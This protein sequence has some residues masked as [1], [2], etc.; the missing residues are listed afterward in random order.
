MLSKSFRTTDAFIKNKNDD[1]NESNFVMN[2]A[3]KSY[4]NNIHY[5]RN[6]MS[7]LKKNDHIKEDSCSGDSNNDINKL[8]S[9]NKVENEKIC[10]V[11]E[12]SSHELNQTYHSSYHHGIEKKTTV[13]SSTM[14]YLIN[15]HKT[16]STSCIDNNKENIVIN[17]QKIN[18]E[19]NEITIGIKKIW[20]R[21]DYR[22]KSIAKAL[23]DAARRNLIYGKVVGKT[24]V[25]FNE[26]TDLG[27]NFALSYTKSEHILAYSKNLNT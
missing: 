11:K 13:I 6:I 16:I 26:P 24:Q 4:D 15:D 5:D 27:L 25:T 19:N 12:E 7:E 22:C 9:C 20:V 2:D 14:K 17:D 3:N 18:V 21:S 10:N 8:Y 23:V 1:G